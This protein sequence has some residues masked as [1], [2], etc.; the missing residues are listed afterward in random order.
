MAAARL[1]A[2]LACC[3]AGCLDQSFLF[4]CKTSDQ[5]TADGRVGTCESNG[6]CSFADSACTSGRRY[7]HYAGADR[8]DQ[9]TECGNGVL[10]VGEECD[11][12]N[13]AADDAC[14]PSCRWNVCGDGFV[15]KNVEE[16]DDGN[17]VGG[18]QCN[19]N[20]L[21]C[22]SGD[23][24]YS[25]PDN[26]HCYTRIDLPRSWDDAQQACSQMGAHLVAYNSELEQVTIR[27]QL[28]RGVTGAHWIGLHDVM[29]A[30]YGWITGEPVVMPM[31]DFFSPLPAGNCATNTGASGA[32]GAAACTAT[33][34]FICEDPGWSIDPKRHHAYR[35]FYG[36]SSWM[37][38]RDACQQRGA[39]LAT[40][41][42]RDEQDY[43]TAQFFGT[44]WLGSIRMD[45]AS[46][47][48]WITGEPFSFQTFADGEPDDT[49]RPTCL[50]LGNDRRW[51]DRTCDGSFRGPYGFICEV[52]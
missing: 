24:H 39:H 8:S 16:C 20:C 35:P 6:H 17:R 31:R 33:D 49:Q 43:V 15:R 40:I 37:A 27:P 13:S 41:T 36:A 29:G 21:R 2:C 51:H 42:D 47:W 50:A 3:L 14:L 18:D 38:A 28:L 26:G 44:F 11:D 48:S 46:D 5:C 34:G 23:A 1:A 9:C 4:V 7:G 12:G 32:W 25:W 10:D 22:A 19:E 30:G 45:A 52:D